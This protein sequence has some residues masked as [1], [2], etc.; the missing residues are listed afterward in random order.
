MTAKFKPSLTTTAI[1]ITSF[2]VIAGLASVSN[3]GPSRTKAKAA[4]AAVVPVSAPAAALPLENAAPT[5]TSGTMGGSTDTSAA[6]GATASAMPGGSSARTSGSQSSAP[7]PRAAG[8]ILEV[9]ANAGQFSTL[10]AAINAA[11]LSE[12]LNGAGPFT[13]FAP[14]DAAFAKLPA[15]TVE[16]LLMP[17][18]KAKLSALL[19][20]HVVPG[21]IASADLAGVTATPAT[22][23]GSTLSVDS[24]SG[25]KVGGATVTSPDVAASNGTIHV[26]DTVLIPPA[27]AQ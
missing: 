2:F 10:V 14:T 11:G 22:V 27:R 12:T 16:S 1:C 17:E 8:N 19:T 7:A 24:S 20:Y 9:A 4:A 25:I 18:N 26:I 21:K 5:G 6:V 3:A 23:Q 15:G 13:V